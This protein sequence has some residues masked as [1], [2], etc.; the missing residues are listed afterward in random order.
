MSAAM[1]TTTSPFL[2]TMIAFLEPYFVAAGVDLAAARTEIVNT[3]A[4]YGTRSRAEIIQSAKIIAFSLCSLATLKD[5]M[6]PDM[7]DSM[8]LR[9]RSCANG[10][11]RSSQQDEKALAARLAGDVPGALEPVNDVPDAAAR[12]AVQD[13]RAAVDGFRNRLSGRSPQPAGVH[14]EPDSNGM[15]SKEA[16]L[17]LP[18]PAIPGSP[19]PEPPMPDFPWPPVKAS[20]EQAE[21]T[22]TMWRD[23]MI[24]VLG[25]MGRPVQ[26]VIAPA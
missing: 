10:L 18:G 25:D 7:S 24:K 3:L 21:R 14:A 6:A 23:A 13:A 5:G 11:D 15:A 2:A 22:K 19:T 17:N 8:R 12:E 26:P 16:G 9:Y 4:T 1:S 20:P